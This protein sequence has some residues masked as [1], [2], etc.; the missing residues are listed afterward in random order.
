MLLS[1]I[2]YYMSIAM[3]ARFS[4]DSPRRRALGST[5]MIADALRSAICSGQVAPGAPLKQ[6]EIAAEFG[7]SPT[8][9]RE[10]LKLLVSEGLAILHH[11]RGCFV[12][13]LSIEVARE[14]TEFRALLEPK[15]ARW[16]LDHLTDGD[17]HQ[18]S[19][20]IAQIDATPLPAARLQLATDFHATI[21]RRADRPF[22]LEQVNRAR[23][24]LNRYW[25]LA[26]R[27]RSFP[28]NTQAEHKR[29][30]DLCVA[31]D[32]DGLAAFIERHILASGEVVLNYLRKA[33]ASD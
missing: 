13:T 24:N 3:N 20:I 9:V 7:I 21:Y 11:N 30:L 26:W 8:P 6:D 25:L 17:I 10:A 28:E 14:L 33:P 32:R 4:L 19:R 2:T 5:E 27:G 15:M 18:A 23:N 1:Q 29:M 12:S 22:F 31:R 16:A